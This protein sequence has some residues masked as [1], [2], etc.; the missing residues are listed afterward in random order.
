MSFPGM[1]GG[2]FRSPAAMYSLYH[3]SDN[4]ELL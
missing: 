2:A 3:A 1:R 4:W